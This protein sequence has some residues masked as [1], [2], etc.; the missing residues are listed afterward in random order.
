MRPPPRHPRC[1]RSPGQSSATGARRCGG[2]AAHDR[3][4]MK[5]T[6]NEDED[7]V[8]A[9]DGYNPPPCSQQLHVGPR[10]KQLACCT[11]S[12]SAASVGRAS[13]RCACWP[14]DQ[15]ASSVET[16]PPHLLQP[17]K[18]TPT[19]G[20]NNAT[21]ARTRRSSLQSHGGTSPRARHQPQARRGDAKDGATHSAP[22]HCPRP[23]EN[24]TKAGGQGAT[25]HCSRHRDAE[26][27]SSHSYWALT[28][29]THDSSHVESRAYA[30][31]KA[32]RS[33][34]TLRKRCNRSF[35]PL[36]RVSLHAS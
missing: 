20:C 8:L 19:D 13:R 3:K 22:K 17:F 14:P 9:P 21:L 11:A 16:P 28:R 5:P 35:Q 33:I 34:E 26:V 32:L 36:A 6:A 12:L 18:A 29:L 2:L 7:G 1:Q 15:L 24:K 30:T 23:T 31:R 4:T 10:Q 25:S 27:Q